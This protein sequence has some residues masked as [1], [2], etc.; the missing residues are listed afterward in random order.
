MVGLARVLGKVIGR[1]LGR[2]DH[3]HSDDVPQWQRPTTSAHVHAHAKET[4]D[5]AE[6]FPGGPRDPSVLT[7]YGDHVVVI[8]WNRDLSS[9][10]RKVH[11]IGRPVP[12]IERLVGATG[13]S[14]LIACSVE[15]DDR[16]LIS[17]FMESFETLHVDEVVLMLS[18]ERKLEMRQHN[19]MG[20]TYAYRGYEICEVGH[21]TVV[22]R[23]YLLHLLGCTLLANKSATHVHSESYAWGAV[24]LCWIYEH[25]PSIV[26]SLSDPDY[27]E[28]SPRVCLWIATKV[29]SKS[30]PASTYQKHLDGLTIVDICWMPYGDHRVVQD[31]DLISCFLGHTRW[32]SIFVRHRP[33]RVVR[34][35][36]YV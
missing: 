3:H 22:A 21:W 28:M 17:T 25:F 18:P 5:D 19:V 16:R 10:G 32:G 14:P 34:K 29:S 12:E 6:G 26:E 1:A 8:V 33:E 27:D 31:F 30:L 36:G 35:F 13:L 23:A 11:K 9:Q 4:V 20:H 24:A 7:V 2:E 15:I